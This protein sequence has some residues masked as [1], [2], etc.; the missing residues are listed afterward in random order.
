MPKGNHNKV[1]KVIIILMGSCVICTL[2]ILALFFGTLYFNIKRLPEPPKPEITYGEFPFRLVYEING[3]QKVV[4]DTLICEYDGIEIDAGRLKHR[5]WKE[6]LKSGKERIVLLKVD[7]KTEIYY[8]PGYGKYYMG[9]ENGVFNHFFPN[10]SQMRWYKGKVSSYGTISA[11]KLLNK[12]NIK[13]ISWDYTE[14][15]ENSFK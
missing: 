7:E 6:Y 9:D 3:E 13:L 15:I 1:I 8:N 4:E 10:A 12:Y 11:K 2:A 5:E 14:P